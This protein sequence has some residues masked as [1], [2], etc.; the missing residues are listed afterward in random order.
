LSQ[1]Y[2]DEVEVASAMSYNE[3]LNVYDNGYPQE[4]LNT[5]SL[6]EE[7]IGFPGQSIFTTHTFYNSNPELCKS[8]VQAS[9]KGWEYAIAHPQEAVDIVMKYDIEKKLNRDHQYKQMLAMIKLI[10][11]DK[12]PLGINLKE[13]YEF[14]TDV[15]KKYGI[16]QKSENVDSYYTNEF[17]TEK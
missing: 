10:M 1:F 12:Y 7:G 6:K 4:K 14:I 8:F 17:I 11:I 16:I 2:N 3:L 5:F 9:I 15:Y 13:D